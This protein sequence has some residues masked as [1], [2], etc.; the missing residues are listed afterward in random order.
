M[1]CVESNPLSLVQSSV[2]HDKKELENKL[3]AQEKAESK[4]SELEKLVET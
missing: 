4:K 3:E 2:T 1:F